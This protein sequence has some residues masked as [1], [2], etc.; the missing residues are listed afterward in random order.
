MSAGETDVT[1]SI[2]GRTSTA[3]VSVAP[4]AVASV[5]SV[6]IE[7]TS[8]TLPLLE[9]AT[10][11]AVARD[12]RGN[13]LI[14]RP[15]TW[16]SLSPA[17]VTVDAAGV[18]SAVSVG[19]ATVTAT[20]EGHVAQAS[21]NVTPPLVASVSVA[22]SA[23][24]IEEGAS[25]QASATLRDRSGAA[26][27]DRAASWSSSNPSVATID[28]ATGAV[29]GT[30][31]GT[32]TLTATAG[33]ITGEA[34][35][36]VTEAAV[37][38]I[39]ILPNP[40]V[41]VVGTTRPLTATLSDSRG[42]ILTGRPVTWSSAQVAVASVHAATGI[43]T[44]VSPGQATIR[45]TSGSAVGATQIVVQEVPVA[46]V[47][48]QLSDSSLVVG[49]TTQGVA[50]VRDDQG[51]VLTGRAVVWTSS[52][53]SVAT[54]TPS[55]GKV[56]AIA[57][58]TAII[59]AT[60]EGKHAD[61]TLSVSAIPV[62]TVS[63]TLATSIISPTQ[64]TQA[65]A[66]LRDA[67]GNLLTGRTIAWSTANMAVAVV[68]PT[69]GLVTAIAPGITTITA[70]SE[71]RS[72]QATITVSSI[73]VAS[74]SVT[75]NASSLAPGEHTQ[76]TA[77]LK[78]SQGNTLS[79]RTV[80]WK[81]SNAAAAS[82]DPSS[83]MVTAIADGA[84][85]IIATAEGITGQ[86]SL[87]VATPAVASV[88]VTLAASSIAAGATT[89]ATA[90]LR[91]AKGALLTGRAVT[92][93]AGN[94]AVA[95]VNPSTGLVTAVAPGSTTIIATSEG[96][97]GQASLTVTVVPVAS[98]VVA[99]A[100]TAID[101]GMTTQATATL[102]DANGNVLT[103]RAVIW[104]TSNAGYATVDNNG[105]VTAVTDGQVYISAWSESVAGQALLTVNPQPVA[106]VSL[107]MPTAL[108]PG[109]SANV[110]VTARDAQGRTLYFRPA[111]LSVSS[112]GIAVIPSSGPWTMCAS[113]G[114]SCVLPGQ[115]IVRWG[116]PGSGVYSY[117]QGGP[118]SKTCGL[119]SFPYDPA[120]GAPNKVC[121][122]ANLAT[123]QSGNGF[124]ALAALRT[125]SAT[126]SA[127][128]EGVTATSTLTVRPVIPMGWASVS[129][130]GTLINSKTL[131]GGTITTLKKPGLGNYAVFFDA[132]G[133]GKVGASFTAHVAT[134][135]GASV[136]SLA[137][138]TS[139]C[140][141]H[142]TINNIQAV[143]VDVVCYTPDGVRADF[144]FRVM[145]VGDNVLAGTRANTQ[146]AA[147]SRWPANSGS[148]PPPTLSWNSWGAPMQV[149]STSTGVVRH[150]HG[151]SIP[152]PFVA[153]SSSWSSASF[154]VQCETESATAQSVD[155]SCLDRASGPT[156]N[157]VVN[158]VLVFQQGRPGQAYAWASVR[159]N[160]LSA[161]KNPAG[162]TT[163]TRLASGRYSVTFGGTSVSG[164][165]PAILLSAAENGGTWRR[166]AQWLVS[167][168]PVKLEVACWD[169]ALAF[170]DTNFDVGFLN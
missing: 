143:G 22:L 55:S 39:A 25:A 30:G 3:H 82:V 4:I 76:A 11:S 16:H 101:P 112:P 15:V 133:G 23:T 137:G 91:D 170:V 132:A 43:V 77:V 106:Q 96:K 32:T 29:T 86:A 6:A 34:T 97:N 38:S 146:Y 109:E 52:A 153:F 72:G 13:P 46:S 21:V 27:K 18:L 68:H 61:A 54:V 26:I 120:F 130:N 10:L 145:F 167:K 140:Q 161:G 129:A 60:A 53:P 124:V 35:L 75:L 57:A 134:D 14:G 67:Q 74:V 163:V 105:L 144:P 28:A 85:T 9:H 78:D 116:V 87:T 49:G 139:V 37:A 121:E 102:K 58:G 100:S 169:G 114:Q 65:S 1:A 31:V 48:L 113:D 128:I 165:D 42:R 152:S 111:T 2:A 162:T 79:G 98:V 73:A 62:S 131:A 108:N 71:G 110:S 56:T 168:S 115:Q 59:T 99:L 51:G 125:G 156:L 17:T 123:V 92:W 164:A 66:A 135:A 84:T 33:G 126:V 94:T 20:I 142:S 147:F 36:Q 127:T 157:S 64:S 122:F 90:T 118:G 63:V 159:S 41:L 7:P 149:T 89:Q 5:A 50:V 80:T 160:T 117:L 138:P 155:V 45:A 70:T 95:T 40:A 141:A 88:T 93:S 107:V 151:V 150:V 83:G 136:M 166:C 44:G 103:G 24:S 158:D 148:T 12:A 8:T 47:S 119:A 69:S 19:E 104:S 154:D 81:S